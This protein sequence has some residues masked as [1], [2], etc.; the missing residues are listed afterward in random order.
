MSKDI[1]AR[2][3]AACGHRARV[4]IPVWLRVLGRRAALTLTLPF[5][6]RSGSQRE[7][8]LARYL[9]SMMHAADSDPLMRPALPDVTRGVEALIR[10]QMR[11]A[12]IGDDTIDELR[13]IVINRRRDRE[14]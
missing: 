8:G 9:L 14:V 12:P 11:L 7:R 2:E 6:P 13:G 1:K 10:L 3:V 4:G 5:G